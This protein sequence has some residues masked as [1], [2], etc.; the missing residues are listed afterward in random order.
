MKNPVT[1]IATQAQ[2]DTHDQDL[3]LA[4]EAVDWSASDTELEG[5]INFEGGNS[6]T[7]C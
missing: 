6:Y 3:I 2:S 5:R 4:Q 7:C 1:S